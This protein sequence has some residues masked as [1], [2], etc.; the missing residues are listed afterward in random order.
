MGFAQFSPIALVLAIPYTNGIREKNVHI[1]QI[2]EIAGI[3]EQ[4]RHA[5]IYNVQNMARMY[6]NHV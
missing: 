4:L 2:T 3:L 1:L 6:R 5:N